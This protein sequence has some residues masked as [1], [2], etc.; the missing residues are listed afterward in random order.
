[1]Q[2]ID[3][4]KLRTISRRSETTRAVFKLWA[5]RERGRQTSNV[6]RVNRVLRDQG[7]TPDKKEIAT[8]LA[9]LQALGLGKVVYGRGTQPT[10]LVWGFDLRS[11]AAAAGFKAV[12]KADGSTEV[13]ETESAGSLARAK[14]PRTRLPKLPQS[15]RSNLPRVNLDLVAP[16]PREIKTV[17]IKKDGITIELPLDLNAD[18]APGIAALLRA[19]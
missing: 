3:I 5:Q 16:V 14:M 2:G 15:A 7:L 1:M 19:L 18:S 8:L 17:T 4:Q 6:R 9:D 10:R 12:D 13:I 11:V